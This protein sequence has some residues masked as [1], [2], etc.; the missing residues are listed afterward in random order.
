MFA[1]GVGAG[2]V[3][4]PR[5]RLDR[6]RD[7]ASDVVSIRFEGETLAVIAHET[8]EQQRVV[9]I[10]FRALNRRLS[11]VSRTQRSLVFAEV[12]ANL[13]RG[14]TEVKSRRTYE[15]LFFR[16]LVEALGTLTISNPIDVA[17]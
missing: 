14:L 7:A 12:L 1:L 2:P 10:S 6:V 4:A 13:S 5:V 17:V 11:R 9:A 8:D 15:H 3:P 16:G